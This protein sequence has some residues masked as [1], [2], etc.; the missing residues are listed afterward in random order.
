MNQVALDFIKAREN[1]KLLAYLDSGGKPT[2]GW[3]ATGPNIVLGTQWTQ[4]E[5]DADL[6]ARVGKVETSVNIAT[7]PVRL[8]RQQEAALIC[9]AYNIGEYAFSQSHVAAFVK[10]GNWI[11]AVKAWL[12]FDHVSGVELRGLLKR[13][14]EEAVLF[15][16]GT[17]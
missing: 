3:G 8:S 7:T 1:C 9:L 15:L 5:A 2:V 14:L 13:R 10:A 4:A 16:E 12:G 11:A 6:N 17:P